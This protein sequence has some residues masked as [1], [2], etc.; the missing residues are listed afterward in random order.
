MVS[1]AM[2]PL[3]ILSGLPAAAGCSGLPAALVRV[4]EDLDYLDPYLQH[5]VTGSPTL[6]RMRE[7][8]RL[9]LEALCPLALTNGTAVVAAGAVRI[10]THVLQ[11]PL[12]ARACEWDL[13]VCLLSILA[14]EGH[15]VLVGHAHGSA[16][17]GHLRWVES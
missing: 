10:A 2:T 17:L 3:S 14:S 11:T 4:L 12:L 1:F 9:A 5:H 13:A 15:N 6:L 8:F 16:S 7:L